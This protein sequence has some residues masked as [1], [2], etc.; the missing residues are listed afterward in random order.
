[1]SQDERRTGTVQKDCWSMH[2]R[3]SDPR[4]SFQS[5]P[6]QASQA[7]MQRERCWLDIVAFDQTVRRAHLL[8]LLRPGPAHLRTHRLASQAAAFHF[9]KS[10]LNYTVFCKCAVDQPMYY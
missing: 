3:V 7:M 10:D 4:L 2:L 6:D 9:V 5:R 1:M 8:A